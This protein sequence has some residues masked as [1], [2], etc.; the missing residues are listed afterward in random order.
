MIAWPPEYPPFE[1]APNEIA[2]RLAAAAALV[3][4][5]LSTGLIDCYVDVA[6]CSDPYPRQEDSRVIMHAVGGEGLRL[7]ESLVLQANGQ[8]TETS[9]W[10]T[11][12]DYSGG[13]QDL[14]HMRLLPHP[15][16]PRQLQ[17]VTSHGP[18]DSE[19]IIATEE[20]ALDT[21]IDLTRAVSD[22]AEY[23]ED[24]PPWK[25]RGSGWGGDSFIVNAR[26][27][28]PVLGH[29]LNTVGSFAAQKAPEELYI[30][31]HMAVDAGSSGR[32]Y[33]F[34][35][36][37]EITL[38]TVNRAARRGASFVLTFEYG[39]SSKDG[40][41]TFV[42]GSLR[43]EDRTD[44]GVRVIK[45]TLQQRGNELSRVRTERISGGDIREI[46]RYPANDETI[47]EMANAAITAEDTLATGD[48]HV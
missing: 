29:L 24:P 12:C 46:G 48:T 7:C 8:G 41:F 5:T 40:E 39:S 1:V 30:D 36:K 33:G 28:V 43:Q 27:L 21:I 9:C 16:D 23:L 19:Q 42:A 14:T 11:I 4:Q 31:A 35:P 20:A 18:K 45:D 22:S 17:Q 3:G 26:L 44:S 25:L 32:I 34:N 15:D 2:P 37:Q 13:G 6:V 47:L 38:A 10:R